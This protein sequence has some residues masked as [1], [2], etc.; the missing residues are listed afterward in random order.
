[1]VHA[2]LAILVLTQSVSTL[3]MIPSAPA[4]KDML[5]E[6]V[7]GNEFIPSMEPSHHDLQPSCHGQ[8]SVTEAESL[9]SCCET[10]DEAGCILGCSLIATAISCL[11]TLEKIDVHTFHPLDSLHTAPFRPLTGLY[12]PPRTS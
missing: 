3:A 5:V 2:L 12:R 1:M 8:R 6:T 7:T 11:S 10:M 4:E 9:Q